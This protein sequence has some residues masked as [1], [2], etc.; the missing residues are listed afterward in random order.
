MTAINI[1]LRCA[2]CGA[3]LCECDAGGECAACHRPVSETIRVEALNGEPLAI[4]ED[5]PCVGC[6]YNLR[7]LLF[8]AKCPE[9]ARDVVDSL[10]RKELHLADVKWLKRVRS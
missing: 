5:T 2:I 7:T 1:H 3:D 10:Q 4:C 6:D 9:C 8:D